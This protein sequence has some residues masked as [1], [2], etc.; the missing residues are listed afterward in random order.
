[1]INMSSHKKNNKNQLISIMDVIICVLKATV[2]LVT[3]GCF[4][5]LLLLLLVSEF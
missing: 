2:T 3:I 4:I 5:A 1:M